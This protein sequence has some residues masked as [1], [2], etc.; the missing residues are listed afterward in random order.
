MT[1]FRDAVRRLQII[2][3]EC[4]PK[5]EKNEGEKGGDEF[6][7]LKKKVHQDVKT[8]RQQLREREELLSLKGTSPE[9]A[10]ASYRVRVAIKAIKEDAT[11]MR[12][13]ASKEERKKDAAAQQRASE[14][15]EIV[16]LVFKH[17]EECETLEKKRFN[18]KVSGE[19]VTLMTGAG[20]GAIT[21][22]SRIPASG[23]TGPAGDGNGGPRSD[24]FLDSDLPDIDVAEDLKMIQANNALIDKE[25]DQMQ[26]G[27]TVL[28]NMAQ[29]MGEELDKQNEMLDTIDT[30][31]DKANEKLDNIN[32]KMKNTLD[33]VMKGDRFM[34][35]CVMLC[36]LLSLAAFVA[37]RFT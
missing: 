17:I 7:K 2:Y 19:R 10:E 20:A 9:T 1:S 18:D 28:K 30:K 4:V 31:V 26:V 13:I 11:R 16:D 23:S 29:G 5:E 25:L 36:I 37:S 21:G 34:L 12:D 15:K 32:V 3:D 35:N 6:S 24:P 14:R 8:V 22:G 33:K 27:I